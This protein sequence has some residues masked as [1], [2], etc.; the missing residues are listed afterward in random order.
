M[1]ETLPKT[2]EVA[3]DLML[4]VEAVLS[5]EKDPDDSRVGM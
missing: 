4:Q 2:V 5:P 3:K 1:H